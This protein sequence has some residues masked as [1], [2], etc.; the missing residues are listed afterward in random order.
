MKKLFARI[1]EC[2]RAH[3]EDVKS[4]RRD[5][6]MHPELGFDVQR[7]AAV[8]ADE[9]EALGIR[10][11]REVG[12]SGV[13]GDI[14][15]PGAKKR[16]AL[17][18]DMDALPMEE[19]TAVPYRSQI[20]GKAHMCGHDVHTATLIGTA[21]VL[22]DLRDRLKTNVRLVFQPSEEAWP[23]GAQAMIAD[24]VLE[25]VDEIYG[26]HTW[27]EFEAGQFGICP[28][29]Y[30]G[31]ADHF[32]IRITGVG[33]HAAMP[34]FAVDPIVIGAQF[35]TALQ[36]IVSR[37]VDPLA[38]AV[39]TVTQFHAGTT[40]NVIPPDAKLVGTVR[41][42]DKEVQVT[43]RDRV[44]KLLAGIVSGQGASH[45]FSYEEGYPVTSNHDL[46]VKRALSVARALVGEEQVVF[47]QTPILGSEDFGYYSR[48]V[49]GCIFN[50]GSG[51]REQGITKMCHDPRFD[52]DE[53]CM[54]YGMAVEAALALTFERGM[55]SVT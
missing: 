44:E 2:S 46:C 35:V 36:S 43:V 30:L 1:F 28:G 26:L 40:D 27:P 22:T 23:G 24:G 50:L 39:V 15:I 32:E 51:N 52:V 11:T 5:I 29:A 45:T 19:L 20:A 25:G 38:S 42:L 10:T 34:S 41:T 48:K 6:H 9:L 4:I 16:I 7:T 49:P 18:A 55:P 3:F 21:G 17:R 47:P 31:Q 33:G 14:E 37:N 8:V 12:K 53:T 13:V 54:I